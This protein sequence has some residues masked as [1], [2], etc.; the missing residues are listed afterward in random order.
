MAAA[1]MRRVRRIGYAAVSGLAGWLVAQVLCLP[2]LLITGVRDSEGQ[3][4]LFVQTML[5]GLL[6]WACWTLLLATVAWVLVVFP[7]VMTVR[8][9]L[10]V[11]LRYWVLAL[12]TAFALWLATRRPTMFRD[13][14][15][16]TFL[17]RFE[18]IIPYTMF[19][20]AFSVVTAWM[21]IVLSKRW[22][23]RQDRE[24]DALA[25]PDA[26]PQPVERPS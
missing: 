4:W 15:G 9:C 2:I 13:S 22:L 10:L 14:T 18:Q 8:P 17:H 24:A 23:E 21:Y 1:T 6:A 11:R 26:A 5:Y 12:G 16:A 20:V 25:T 7:L 19:A 3:P